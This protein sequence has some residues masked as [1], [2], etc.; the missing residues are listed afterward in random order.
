MGVDLKGYLLCE[1]FL[2]YM[3]WFFKGPGMDQQ[4]AELESGLWKI[5]DRWGGSCD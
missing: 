2:D 1:K 4:V 5:C 3:E